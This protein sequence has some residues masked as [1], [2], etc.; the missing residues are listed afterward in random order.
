[1]ML[2]ETLRG[3]GRRWY[4]VA[5]GIVLA[6]AAAGGAMYLIPPGYERSANQLLIPGADS[7][8]EGANPY[9]FLGGLSPAAD[10]LVRAIGSENV[11][12]EVTE[13][14]PGVDIEISRDTSTAGPIIVIV[15]TASNDTAA[16]EVLELLV[17]R[18]G[19]VLDDLQ[20]AESIAPDNRV[21]VQPITVDERSTLQQRS[22]IIAAA[23]AGMGVLV[24][25]LL[26]AGLVDG[27]S[28]R[29]RQRKAA[30]AGQQA[31]EAPIPDGRDS[32]RRTSPI[33]ATK[34][35]SLRFEQ[36]AYGERDDAAVSSVDR[37]G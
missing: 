2:S 14:H 24:L 16:E 29:R 4:I 36:S 22:R 35:P 32:P 20:D 25:T 11:L 18:T 10:V 19:D 5:P 15:V 13:E 37:P 17:D 28:M 1:M 34:A 3:L 7:V 23:A 31:T 21:T 27:L 8:P 12:N 33:G 26:L 30:A 9:L 6:A